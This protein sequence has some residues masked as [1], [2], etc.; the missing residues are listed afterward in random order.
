[1]GLAPTAMV[2]ARCRFDDT[3]RKD[4]L[5][6]VS[7]AILPPM[8]PKDEPLP[9]FLVSAEYATAVAKGQIQ[10]Q[11]PKAGIATTEFWLH[12]LGLLVPAA[13]QAAGQSESVVALAISQIAA[14]LYTLARTWIKSQSVKGAAS[15]A[16]AAVSP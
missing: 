3:G 10:A 13:L 4:C 5:G 6:L 16:T 15:V 7:Y 8:P 1:M 11:A 14:S 9:A 12:V 2:P